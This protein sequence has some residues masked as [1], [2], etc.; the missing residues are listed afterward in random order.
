METPWSLSAALIDIA[1]ESS[2]GC[3]TI[4]IWRLVHIFLFANGPF[5]EET[6][7]EMRVRRCSVLL[8]LF[9]LEVTCARAYNQYYIIQEDNNTTFLPKSWHHKQVEAKRKC[10]KLTFKTHIVNH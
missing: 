4:S 7:E 2:T 9:L 5:F 10:Y 6:I 8:L 1:V 3:N